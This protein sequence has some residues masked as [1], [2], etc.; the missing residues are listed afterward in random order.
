[1]K[2]IEKGDKEKAE[3]LMEQHVLNASENIE[4]L[5]Y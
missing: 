4:K 3:A 1:M 5:K 2:A